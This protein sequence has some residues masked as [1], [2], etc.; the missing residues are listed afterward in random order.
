MSGGRFDYD[1][2]RIPQIAESIE[3]AIHSNNTVNEWGNSNDFSEAT[4]LEF[5][6]AVNCLNMAY[7][8]AQRIDWL[9][10]G[11]DGEDTFHQRLKQDLERLK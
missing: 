5:K 3:S 9:L 8:Y 2:N 11:D 10:S 6:R 4:L 7:V 1:Q